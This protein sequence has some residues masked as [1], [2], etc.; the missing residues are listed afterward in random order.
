[1]RLCLCAARRSLSAAEPHSEGA[2][3]AALDALAAHAAVLMRLHPPYTEPLLEAARRVAALEA[4][5][6]APAA[7]SERSR[8]ARAKLRKLRKLHGGMLEELQRQRDAI[9]A[10]LGRGDDGAA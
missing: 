1:M 10:L 5:L 2:A 9:D 3:L 4:R 6:R 8:V 7:T